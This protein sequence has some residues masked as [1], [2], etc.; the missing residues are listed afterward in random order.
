MID[1]KEMKLKEI[2]KGLKVYRQEKEIV[3]SKVDILVIEESSLDNQ[4]RKLKQ[5]KSIEK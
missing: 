5:K 4:A 1:K 3:M 2:N